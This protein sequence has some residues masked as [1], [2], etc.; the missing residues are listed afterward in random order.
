[1]KWMIDV[2]NLNKNFFL[3]TQGE[4]KIPVFRD[5]HLKLKPGESVALVGPSGVGKST[6]LRLL[7]GNYKTGSGKILVRHNGDVLNMAG[8]D[9]HMILH[10]R[11]WTIGYVSQF[12]RVIPRVP[13]IRV[14]MEPLNLR[15]VSEKEARPRAEELLTRLRIPERL[16]PL[17]PT[18]FSGGEQQRINIARGFSATYPVMLLDEPT[19]SLDPVNSG[20]VVEIIK[21]A[22]SQDT[23]VIGIFH[24]EDVRNRLASRCVDI[25]PVNNHTK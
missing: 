4:A 25:Q 5:F 3:H 24:D 9:P 13:A 14:V 12:L 10:I 15:G 11:K 2:D 23:S 21:E 16:W 7:Y 18:T 19:A 22:L 17:S 8:A 1:M 6:F 20:T